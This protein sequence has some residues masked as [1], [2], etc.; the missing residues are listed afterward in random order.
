MYIRLREFL[1]LILVSSIALRAPT[2]KKGGEKKGKN[3]RERG[4]GGEGDCVVLITFPMNVP[5]EGGKRRGEKDFPGK[6][7]RKGKKRFY[8]YRKR[9]KGRNLGGG[10][11]KEGDGAKTF[12]F[13][14]LLA[15][16]GGGLQKGEAAPGVVSAPADSAGWGAVWKRKGGGKKEEK[17]KG[18]LEKTGKGGGRGGE[19][20]KRWPLKR[21]F[22]PTAIAWVDAGPGVPAGRGASKKKKEGKRKR[23]GKVRSVFFHQCADRRVFSKSWERL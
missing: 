17:E 15:K 3:P 18:F 2:G 11:K 12:F 10:E 19:G 20:K 14:D 13:L 21:S 1:I 22:P 16:W 8:Q 4:E 6:K 9:G 7:G 5:R 23:G